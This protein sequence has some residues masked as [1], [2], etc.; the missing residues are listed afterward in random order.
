M[1]EDEMVSYPEHVAIHIKENRRVHLRTGSAPLDGHL[2]LTRM[3]V[4]ALLAILHGSLEV[5]DVWWETA[6]RIIQMSCRMRDRCREVLKE[7]AEAGDRAR[8]RASAVQAEAAEEYV[9]E[10]AERAAVSIWKVVSG[11]TDENGP[12]LNRK[13]ETDEGCSARCISFAIRHNKGSG[14]K[15]EALR[16]AED[17]DWIR[18]DEDGKYTPGPSRPA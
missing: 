13:H 2:V 17:L 10:R 12:V 3:K 7:T 4:A 14:V 9:S 15:D 11:H 8:G 16:I 5:D 1:G 18:K 6:G